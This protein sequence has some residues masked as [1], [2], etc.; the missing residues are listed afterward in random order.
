M[1]HTV[2]ITEDETKATESYCNIKT[3]AM[4]TLFIN[5]DYSDNKQT[6]IRYIVSTWIMNLP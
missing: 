6:V 1:A 2:S 3:L 4:I 5:K